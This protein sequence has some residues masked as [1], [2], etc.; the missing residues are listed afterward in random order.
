MPLLEKVAVFDEPAQPP[1]GSR[2]S[3]GWVQPRASD[4]W[5]RARLQAPRLC[6][7]RSRKKRQGRRAPAPTAAFKQAGNVAQRCLEPWP[8]LPGSGQ[9]RCQLGSA[10][11]PPA[12]GSTLEKCHPPACLL[13]VPSGSLPGQ[14]VGCNCSFGKISGNLSCNCPKCLLPFEIR[15][16]PRWCH[17]GIRACAPLTRIY[18]TTNP[19]M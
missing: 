17:P 11:S 18:Y 2:I 3:Q 12:R 5:G 9:A 14:A 10:P 4:H 16:E 7:G 15:L 13:Q 1:M 6:A 8:E 19:L